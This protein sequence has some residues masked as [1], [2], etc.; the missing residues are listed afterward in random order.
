MEP[1][2]LLRSACAAP[3]TTLHLDPHGVARACGENKLYQLGTYPERSLQQIWEGVELGELRTALEHHNF[4]RGCQGCSA[5]LDADTR[6]FLRASLYDHLP[7]AGRAPAQPVRLELELSNRCNLECIMCNGEYSSSIRTRREGRSPLPTVYDEAFFEELATLVDGLAEITFVGGEPF[8]GPE[9]LR[10]FESLAA[11]SWPGLCHVTTNGTVVNDR[12]EH[13]LKT[14]RVNVAVSIDGVTERTVE[15]I[16]DGASFIALRQN[17]DWFR[18]MATDRGTSMVL[19]FCLQQANWHE[20]YDFLVW[21]DELDVDVVVI[22]IRHPFGLS[23]D[24]LPSHELDGV[25]QQLEAGA[26]AGP[27]L[28]RNASAWS[29]ELERIRSEAGER[30]ETPVHLAAGSTVL[31]E[32]VDTATAELAEW[33][34]A[35]GTSIVVFD[36]HG[37]LADAD[38]Q[39]SPL[40]DVLGADLTDFVGRHMVELMEPLSE[41]FGRFRSSEVQPAYGGTEVQTIEFVGPNGTTMVKVLH[42]APTNE[43]PAQFRLA[44]N[45]P[46]P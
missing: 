26:A 6:K 38:E 17:I 22:P 34:D 30:V 8:L 20:L 14:L 10:V 7:V 13:L 24:S 11:R 41:V 9:P 31:G 33:A 23:L 12:V 19:H 46:T 5:A 18:Q 4:S 29:R 37:C 28:R 44:A 32:A 16:R 2:E 36:E 3:F 45:G 35:R 25:L 1:D 27:A 39:V 40:D 21:A 15:L 43:R 42:V